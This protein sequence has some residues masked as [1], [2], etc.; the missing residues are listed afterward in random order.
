MALND[1][2]SAFVLVLCCIGPARSFSACDDVDVL[3]IVCVLSSGAHASPNMFLFAIQVDTASVIHASEELLTF[4][5]SIV[6]DGS[7]EDA[8]FSVVLYGDVP[9][10][11]DISLVSLEETECIH[12]RKTLEAAFISNLTSAFAA[13]LDDD[14]VTRSVDLLD[15]C[16]V[17]CLS[18]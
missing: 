14:H 18:V 15:T 7:S 3:F 17:L 8:G 6:M 5:D 11:M 4:I 9:E 1:L 12:R 13:I 2:L 10:G 16:W